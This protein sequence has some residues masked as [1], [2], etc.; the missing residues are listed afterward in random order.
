MN[1]TLKEEIKCIRE[2]YKNDEKNYSIHEMK[3]D[4]GKWC[5]KGYRLGMERFLNYYDCDEKNQTKNELIKYC[6]LQQETLR[7]VRCYHESDNFR[8]GI[9][10]EIVFFDNVL[11]RLEFIKENNE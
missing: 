2:I 8:R 5:D 3:D 10:Y 4:L 7:I 6:H 9:T 1:K 11:E